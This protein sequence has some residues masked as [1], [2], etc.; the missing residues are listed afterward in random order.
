MNETDIRTLLHQAAEPVPPPDYVDVVRAKA[1]AARRRRTIGG[2][3]AA[4]AAVLVAA[5]G[6]VVATGIDDS[7]RRSG[8]PI[9]TPTP[10]PSP[11]ATVS[12]AWTEVSEVPLSHRD[13]PLVADVAG[14]IVVVGGSVP[15]DCPPGA[16]CPFPRGAR[17]GAV[18]DPA[19]GA[20]HQMSNPP[21]R[22]GAGV[23]YGVDGDRLIVMANVELWMYDLSTDTWT[24]PHSPPLQMRGDES[25]TVGGGK[26]YLL[27]GEKLHTETRYQVLDLATGEWSWLPRSTNR[28]ILQLRKLF[29]TPYGIVVVGETGDVN[30]VH[31]HTQ[32]EILVRGGWTR[33]ADPY[34]HSTGWPWHW[35]GSRLIAPV[36]NEKQRRG[37]T[38]DLQ[39]RT[40]GQL[41]KPPDAGG[42]WAVSAAGDGDLVI[43][44]IYGEATGYVYDDATQS[45]TQLGAPTRSSA[46]AQGSGTFVDGT[47]YAVDRQ[48]RLWKLSE[49]N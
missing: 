43:A 25:M 6:V 27:P 37:A 20:W 21:V 10:T 2:V 9:T 34:L 18:Y 48:S 11:P 28:P 33:L 31:L 47:L 44:D 46:V 22:L 36:L 24:Q 8:E 3:A 23:D 17:G 49:I 14:S 13:G 7:S 26:L 32:A 5:T 35:T 42:G 39:T 1:P 40:W 12:D 30:G 19:T 4:V 15:F 29:V 45:W 38:L 41:P 16:F